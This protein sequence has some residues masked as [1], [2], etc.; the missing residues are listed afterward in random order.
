MQDLDKKDLENILIALSRQPLGDVLITY[1][2]VVQLIKQLDE[3][4]NEK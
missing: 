3:P 1:N 2:K 4:T